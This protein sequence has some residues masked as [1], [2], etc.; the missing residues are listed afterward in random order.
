MAKAGLNMMTQS[1]A[2]EL[3]PNIRV[4]G[5]SPGAILWPSEGDSAMPDQTAILA[6]VPLARTG[7][8][9]DIA[10]TA[11][12]LATNAPYISGQVIPVDGGRTAGA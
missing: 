5:I 10:N 3:A 9:S 2:L 11:L 6:K 8:A 4:N 12:F 1:L 7:E